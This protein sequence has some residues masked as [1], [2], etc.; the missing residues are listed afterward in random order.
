V[1]FHRSISL[2]SSGRLKSE[3]V[4]DVIE[5]LAFFEKNDPLRKD[6]QNFVPKR[7]TNFRIHVLLANFVKFGQPKIG[8]VVRYLPDKKKQIFGSPSLS[9]FCADRT[10]NLSGPAAN[11]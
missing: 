9:R 11:I 1:S 10:Q 5:K 6:F 7:F 4:G 8:K 3:V 2:E